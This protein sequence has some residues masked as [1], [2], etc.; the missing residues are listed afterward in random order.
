MLQATKKLWLSWPTDKDVVDGFDSEWVTEEPAS[1]N[2]VIEKGE[3][4][5]TTRICI[6]F[7]DGPEFNIEEFVGFIL[8]GTLK[9]V[10][11]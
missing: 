11:G 2:G 10:E 5:D 1:N 3:K 9:L 4:L 6:D 8:D 7:P